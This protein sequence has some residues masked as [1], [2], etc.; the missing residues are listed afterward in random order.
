LL[1]SRFVIV[2]V[3]RLTS[4]VSAGSKREPFRPITMPPWPTTIFI[5]DW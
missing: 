5:E 4:L 2:A 3:N 1:S